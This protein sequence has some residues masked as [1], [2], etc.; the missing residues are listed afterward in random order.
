MKRLIIFL[1]VLLWSTGV[2][3][4]GI[5]DNDVTGSAGPEDSLSIVIYSLDSIGTKQAIAAGDS[6]YLVVFYPG[7]AEAFR[8]SMAGNDASIVSSSWEDFAGAPSYNYKTLVGT[9]DGSGVEGVYSYE[10]I[11]D[12]V[13][14]GLETPI[15]GTFQLYDTK[16]LSEIL[17]EIAEALDSLQAQDGWVGT[18]AKQTLIIDTVNAVIDTLQ[19]QDDW[20]AE[21]ANLT[22]AIDS[23]NAILDTLQ[24]QDGWIATAANLTLAIDSV[25]AILDSLQLQDGWVAQ[26]TS[27]FDYTSNDVGIDAGS[28]DDI[29]DEDSTGHYT[30]PNMAFVASQTA[31]GSGISDA[32]FSTMAETLWVTRAARTITGD[33]YTPDVNVASMDN[34]VITEGK[35]AADAITNSEIKDGAIDAGAIAADAI[36]EAKIATDAIGSDELATTGTAEIADTTRELILRTDLAPGYPST[37]PDTVSAL[38]LYLA[39][40]LGY[41]DGD[42]SDG[43]DADIGDIQNLVTRADKVIA[44]HVAVVTGAPAA[45]GFAVTGSPAGYGDDF[46]NDMYAT[47]F[48]GGLLGRSALVTDWITANDSLVAAFF[49]APSVGDS[50]VISFIPFD[51]GDSLLFQGAAGALDSGA[52]YGAVTQ[53]HEDSILTV[54][55][56]DTIATGD[57]IG[58][59]PDAWTDDDST[60]FQGSASGLTAEELA[61]TLTNRG[62]TT[63]G[64]VNPCTLFVYDT[65]ASAVV[66]TIEIDAQNAAGVT[67]GKDDTDADGSVILNLNDGTY[68]LRIPSNSGYV[69]TTNPE[70]L[71]VS[72]AGLTDTVE[73]TAFDPADPAAAGTGTIYGYIYDK[74]GVADSGVIVTATIPKKFWP[75][76]Y[77]GTLITPFE[78]LDTTDATGYW[79][80]DLYKYGGVSDTTAYYLIEA[81]SETAAGVVGGELFKIGYQMPDS[82]EHK[83]LFGGDFEQD[84]D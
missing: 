17:D 40:I 60:A 13:S 79:S 20:I 28:V 33:T 57:S 24:L 18:T 75:L 32:D 59:M 45:S 67:A 11:V 1:M 5:V 56:S 71:T 64:G 7:G 37:G 12:D 65:G 82:T 51:I 26:E 66:A 47:F 44:P 8:D 81:N 27:L 19:N 38:L 77:S 54:V 2:G 55:A 53:F 15:S 30:S 35:I 48:T 9:I 62:T 3:A 72:A 10:F 50:L 29:W 76:T 16:T 49:S 41:T 78:T 23:I 39:T 46:F 43:I 34:N 61:D 84:I 52:V 22:L 25:N 74:A 70:T 63:G 68:Y 4:F 6:V 83:L 80:L 36:T 31:A 21:A 58:K 42:G 69:Q 73:V 14:T